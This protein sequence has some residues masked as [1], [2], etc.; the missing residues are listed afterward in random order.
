MLNGEIIR[1]SYIPS[2]K[3]NFA[4]TRSIEYKAEL[5]KLSCS[6]LTGIEQPT[7]SKHLECLIGSET[8]NL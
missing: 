2:W 1:N 6:L 7:A 4:H 8:K 3:T 5:K